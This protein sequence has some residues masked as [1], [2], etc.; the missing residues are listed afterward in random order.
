MH[1]GFFPELSR[2]IAEAGM[3]AVSF[4]TS[5]SG[6]GD[7]L[8]SLSEGEAFAR[9][10]FSHDIEDIDLVCRHVQ[11]N[12]PGVD[13][14]RMAI[15]GHS[16]GGGMALLHA[17]R[18]GLYRAVVLW[19]AIDRVK[20]FDEST[21]ERWRREGQVEIPNGRT[22]Q[23]HRIGLGLLDDIESNAQALDIVSAAARLQTPTLVV[24]GSADEAVPH[25]AALRIH[26]ALPLG[27]LRTIQNAGHTFGAVHP[28]QGVGPDLREAMDA[29]LAHLSQHLLDPR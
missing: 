1:W 2:R 20:L 23:V 4:N 22:G 18:T 27:Q 26:A 9:C 6:V 8:V 25:S 13:A 19:G 28:F 14:D 3:V 5:G 24:H 15:L 29:S 16:R 10:T 21:R 7:D 11:Q 12:L 17:E